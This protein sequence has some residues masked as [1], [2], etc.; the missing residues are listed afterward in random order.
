MQQRIE[1]IA[2][3]TQGCSI[4][5]QRIFM[6]FQQLRKQQKHY[7]DFEYL[8]NGSFALV[9]KAFNKNSQ[10]QVALKIVLC[11]Q[12]EPSEE[13]SVLKEYNL[14]LKIKNCPY[15][16]DVYNHF[17]VYEEKIIIE[18]SDDEEQIAEKPKKQNEKLK[19]FLVLELEFCKTNLA[20]YFR[21]CRHQKQY[22]DKQMKEILAIQILDGI[23]FLHQKSFLHRDI[24]PNNILLQ[25]DNQNN[26]I[27]KIC[28]LAFASFISPS[29]SQIHTK[30]KGTREYM[31]PELQSDIWRK[32]SDLFQVGI[33]LLEL[34][35]IEKFDFLKTTDDERYALRN[36]QIFPTYFLDRKSNIFQIAQ[37]F[38]NPNFKERQSAQKFLEQLLWKDPQ[39]QNI[40]L[41]SI[42]IMPQLGKK[43]H[44][45]LNTNSQQA[46]GLNASQNIQESMLKS[47]IMHKV[48]QINQQSQISQIQNSV[49]AMSLSQIYNDQIQSLLNDYQN[50]IKI[51]KIFTEDELKKAMLQLFNK[52]NYSK[53]FYL[54]SQGGKGLIIGAYNL[55]DKRDCVLKIQKVQSKSRIIKEISILK[56]C[57]MPL[58]V[59]LYDFFYL[60]VVQKEDFVVY[61]LEKCDCDLKAY[62]E[63]KQN[64]QQFTQ[65]VKEEIA[66]QMM[67]SVNY[68]HKHNIIHRDIK[69]QNFLVQES[70]SSIPAIK[71]SDFDEADFL[72]LDE[73]YG[74]D[75][76]GNWILQQY[77]AP[78]CD[79]CGTF[80]YWA[81][82]Q[83]YEKQSTIECDVFSLGIS[84]SLLDNFQKLQPVYHY[85]CLK[86]G[87]QFVEPFEP[88][89]GQLDLINRQTKIYQKAIMYSL[90]YDKYKR[91]DLPQ[92]LDNFKQNYFSKEIKQI[93]LINDH[94]IAQI[95]FKDNKIGAEGAKHI[96]MSLEKCQNITSLNLNLWE[97]RIGAEG[98]KHIG[99]SLEKCQ[100]ITSLNLNV[101]YNYIGAEGAKHIGM[102]L[103]KCQ[104]ITFLNLNLW[105]NRIGAEGAKHI[106]MSLE[107]CQNITSLNLNLWYNYIGAEGAKHIG[108]S[109]EKCQN[110]TS[111]NLNLWQN[112]I[113]AEGAKHIGMSLEKC[114]N[115]TSLN[116]N[117]RGNEI[118]AEGA[119][120]IGMSLEKCQNITSLNL[121]LW[122]NKIGAEGAK[123]I[124]MSLEKCQ[125]ITSLNLN[126]WQFCQIFI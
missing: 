59:K 1:E 95:S 23:S 93:S 9:I 17:Y 111:L 118:G 7:N 74:Y 126:L 3:K 106:G 21:Y 119:K 18:D 46:Q 54:I 5:N 112:N 113:G 10:R 16:V 42:I 19:S 48:S 36:G 123:H 35:N 116:L 69:P 77:F 39:Y 76:N 88:Y 38:L 45:I 53:S 49:Q 94:Q 27:I 72:R 41:S 80:G 37:T 87:K 58:I 110:I 115:I 33:V 34:D 29:Q 85:E 92:I 81:P 75:S 83:I 56:C 4:D 2:K 86:I 22:P 104:N 67:D 121:N 24:K 47:Q 28:D 57:Q 82:E 43:V 65:E 64:D 125:N 109:L 63:K 66:I 12:N 78:N 124:G 31:P 114:Q 122:D 13:E 102:S 52:Q 8:G 15:L 89:K 30:Q 70:N 90:V 107:K 51:K 96:G 25:F 97:N 68:I 26:P 50:K 14:L 61:E 6:F 40:E 103:E 32:E 55:K 20:D 101:R 84:L 120:H 98:A 60:N 91:K 100:N 71:L 73:E 11:N 108:M 62:L 117:V 79:G 99:M 44:E 105:E